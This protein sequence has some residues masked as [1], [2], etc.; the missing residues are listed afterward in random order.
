MVLISP[1]CASGAERLRQRPVG[2]GVRAEAL[3]EGDERRDE[4]LV[5]QVRDRTDRARRACTSALCTTVRVDSETMVSRTPAVRAIRSIRR[6]ARYSAASAAC[7]PS[8]KPATTCSTFGVV[9]RCARSTAARSVGT[10]RQSIERAPAMAQLALDDL[11]RLQAIGRVDEQHAEAA[12]PGR[13]QPAAERV[14]D[15]GPGNRGQDAAAVDRAERRRRRRGGSAGAAPRG[16]ATT[17]SRPAR[18]RM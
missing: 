8:S 15:P 1:L 18:P 14:G 13:R 17:M 9:S 12:G 7:R 11:G 2:R 5:G 16:R 10:M 3:V 6:R 4:A